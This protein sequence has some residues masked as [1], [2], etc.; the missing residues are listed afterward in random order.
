MANSSVE[1]FDRE[2][3]AQK[4][5]AVLD[6][7]IQHG[8]NR[9]EACEALGLS[10]RTVN[11]WLSSG[12]LDGYLDDLA[13]ARTRDA[14]N[15]ILNRWEDI[16]LHMAMMASGERVTR[17]NPVTAAEWCAKFAGIKPQTEP[18]P[19]HQTN[20]LVHMPEQVHFDVKDGTPRL[21]GEG[22]PVVIKPAAEE[23]LDGELIDDD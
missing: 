20:I 2:V 10:V 11:S 8:C 16:V 12:V 7:Q 1:K 15:I 9:T 18:A 14:R 23:V 19:I 13:E 5:L 17:G 6:Y 21:T 3:K 22:R 4:C